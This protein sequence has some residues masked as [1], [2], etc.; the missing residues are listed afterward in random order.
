MTKGQRITLQAEWWPAACRAQGWKVSNRDLR[1]RVLSVAVSYQTF[2]SIL[3]CLAAIN[4]P[5]ELPRQLDSANQLNNR[6]DIDAVKR[7]LLMLADNVAAAREVD[8]PEEGAA[9]RGRFVI[10]ELTQCLAI[11]PVENPMGPEGAEA[12][13]AKLVNDMFN[14]GSRV[15]KK[16]LDDLSEA[17]KF[18]RKKGSSELKE[19]PSQLSRLIMRLSGVLN[20]NPQGDGKKGFRVAARHTQHQMRQL[21]G[22]QCL[23]SCRVC[24]PRKQVTVSTSDNVELPESV[25]HPF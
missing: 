20:A 10:T 19:G 9:R 7:V 24:H 12:Y 2:P 16:T 25:E 13:V 1:L 23:C 14:K 21:A 3:D 22:V 15:E 11:Y 6:E 5:E 8:A 17:P 18:Y 4:S